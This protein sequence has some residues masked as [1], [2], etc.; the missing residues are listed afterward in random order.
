MKFK[1]IQ[2][3][4]TIKSLLNNRLGPR[5]RQI[6]SNNNEFM[7]SELR[8]WFNYCQ[9]CAAGLW[10]V[11]ILLSELKHDDLCIKYIFKNIDKFTSFADEYFDAI[12]FCLS[13]M[14]GFDNE[15]QDAILYGYEEIIFKPDTLLT[16][17]EYVQRGVVKAPKWNSK[18]QSKLLHFALNDLKIIQN[19]VKF[20]PQIVDHCCQNICKNNFSRSFIENKVFMLFFRCI[21]NHLYAVSHIFCLSL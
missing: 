12:S 20:S 2:D 14:H 18:W 15:Y 21:Y 1:Q 8:K 4:K 3:E 17:E 13:R 10:S 11:Y 6:A 19:D 7:Y 9:M 5:C 16:H